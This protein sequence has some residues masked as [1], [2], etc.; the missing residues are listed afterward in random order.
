MS[1]TK[2]EPSSVVRMHTCMRL[3]S[4][5]RSAHSYLRSAH[6]CV[7]LCRNVV[8]LIGRAHSF[9]QRCIAQRG[10]HMYLYMHIQNGGLESLI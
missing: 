2:S 9:A 6:S 4:Q 8:N 7:C 10:L 5:L 1:P 3:H